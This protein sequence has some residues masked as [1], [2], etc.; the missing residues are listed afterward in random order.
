[1]LSGTTTQGGV[2]AQGLVLRFCVPCCH[3]C[4]RKVQ[5]LQMLFACF[6]VWQQEW[7]LLLPRSAAWQ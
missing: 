2:A 3:A 5:G 7:R 4:C 6:D 1:V